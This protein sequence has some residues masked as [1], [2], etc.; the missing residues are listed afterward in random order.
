MAATVEIYVWRACPFCIRAKGLLDRKGVTYSEYVIDGDERAREAMA[1]RFDFHDDV[2][3]VGDRGGETGLG[4]VQCGL[5]W[6]NR[7]ANAHDRRTRSGVQLRDLITTRR[8][9]ANRAVSRN[10][11]N[12]RGFARNIG[13]KLRAETRPYERSEQNR[14]FGLDRG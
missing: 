13:A 9:A 8:H 14:R 3:G 12:R 10:C 1:Q 6:L 11:Y 4:S 5:S 7:D 2:G